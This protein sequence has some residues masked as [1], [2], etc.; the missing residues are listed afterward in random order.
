MHI[1]HEE[2]ATEHAFLVATMLNS[3]IASFVLWLVPDLRD[4]IDNAVCAYFSNLQCNTIRTI[5]WPKQRA[6]YNL[7]FSQ[8]TVRV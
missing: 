5:G 2:V 4:S 1:R 8:D 3:S 6:W 7:I